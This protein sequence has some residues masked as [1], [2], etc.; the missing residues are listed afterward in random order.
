M[1]SALALAVALTAIVPPLP[2]LREPAPGWGSSGYHER[3]MAAANPSAV[4]AWAKANC[5]SGL[6]LRAGAPRTQLEIVLQ[7][8]AT[9][10]A[11]S[12]RRGIAG[13]CADA[14][15]ATSSITAP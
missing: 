6:E 5:N 3:I 2:T 9:Y 11:E 12:R 7:I 13:V 15:A 1:A 4:L 8:S 14:L 10:D